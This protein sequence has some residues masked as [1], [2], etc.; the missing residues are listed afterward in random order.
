LGFELVERGTEVGF[1]D[2]GEDF[3]GHVRL[4]EAIGEDVL[5]FGEHFCVG[6][7]EGEAVDVVE[8]ERELEDGAEECLEFN[9]L[10]EGVESG[11]AGVGGLTESVFGI[12]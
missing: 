11:C 6:G 10:V 12:K 3:L 4:G 9:D 1:A 8:D 2:E 7:G 5:G